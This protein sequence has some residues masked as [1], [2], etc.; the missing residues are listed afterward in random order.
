VNSKVPHGLLKPGSKPLST[1]RASYPEFRSLITYQ[2]GH[3]RN[4]TH[5]SAAS[6]A[7]VIAT[8][9]SSHSITSVELVR[10]GQSPLRRHLPNKEGWHCWRLQIEYFHFIPVCDRQRGWD[11]NDTKG[12]LSLSS[13]SY[14]YN[15]KANNLRSHP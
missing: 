14:Y 11:G 5:R 1:R 9:S 13:L 8:P 7:I 2:G 3:E 6:I 4:S 10:R 12:P 15:M